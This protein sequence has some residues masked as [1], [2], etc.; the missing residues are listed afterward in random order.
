MKCVRMQ[1]KVFKTAD[2]YMPCQD[3]ANNQSQREA[4]KKNLKRKYYGQIVK[5][6]WIPMALAAHT[7]CFFRKLL[8]RFSFAPRIAFAFLL[9]NYPQACRK[10]H[11]TYSIAIYA[12]RTHS[13]HLIST[14]NQRHPSRRAQN[15]ANSF[16]FLILS[17]HGVPQPHLK[18]NRSSRTFR[19]AAL[20]HTADEMTYTSP[21]PPARS[22]MFN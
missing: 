19:R 18:R 3:Q 1:W 20:L 4:K 15:C 22:L 7:R 2:S 8:L 21:L 13:S 17:S 9:S 16:Q 5:Y 11:C 14:F 12:P 6:F 10:S